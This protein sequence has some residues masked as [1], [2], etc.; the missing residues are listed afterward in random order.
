MPKTILKK[1][2]L[3]NNMNYREVQSD[4]SKKRSKLE[5]KDR[6]WLKI[7]SYKNVGWD[8]VISL[9]QKID[10]FLER[11]AWKEWSLEDLFLEADRI[12]NKYL[13][14]QEIV[15]FNQ[16]LSQEVNEIAEE[17]DRQFPDTT[18]EQIDFSNSTKDNSRKSMFKRHLKLV[19][20]NK[21]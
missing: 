10:E 20:F 1:T 16:K 19:R 4:N 17:I 2:R 12:G 7:N 14:Y 21:K 3:F 5:K 18:I 9:H 15:N 8:N 11:D 6:Q 13:T